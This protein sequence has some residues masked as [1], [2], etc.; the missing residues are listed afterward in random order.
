MTD[1]LRV[2]IADDHPLF[3]TGLRLALDHTDGIEVV[4]EAKTG[5]EAVELSASLRPDIVVMDLDLPELRGVD[6]TRRV[7][8]ESPQLRVLVLTMFDDDDSVFAAMRAGAR[9][10][11]LKGSDQADIAR[12]VRAVAAGEAIFGPS[13]AHRIIDFFARP[14]PASAPPAFPQLSARER[15][16]LDLVAAGRSNQAIAGELFLSQKTVRNHISNI[17]AKLQIADR[18]QAIVLAREAGL[19]TPHDPA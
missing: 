5:V 10:Y 15:E 8:A 6:A 9:G 4:G 17:F 11:L 3:R 12:A 19:G 7:V 18:S 16:V 2:L 1:P 14:R 13:V